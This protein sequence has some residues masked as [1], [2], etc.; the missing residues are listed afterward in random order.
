MAKKA[1][2]VLWVLA[3]S[4][5]AFTLTTP[6]VAYCGLTIWPPGDRDSC[7]IIGGCWPSS[8]GCI[9]EGCEWLDTIIYSY[10]CENF[11]FACWFTVCEGG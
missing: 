11:F 3:V 1:M 5:L 2:P 8:G 10:Y 7:E 4:L 6:A 9:E